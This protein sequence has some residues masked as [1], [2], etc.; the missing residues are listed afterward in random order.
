MLQGTC[1]NQGDNKAPRTKSYQDPLQALALK[2]RIYAKATSTVYCREYPLW[3]R[4]SKAILEILRSMTVHML[5]NPKQVRNLYLV[6]WLINKIAPK[7]KLQNKQHSTT[8]KLHQLLWL[9]LLCYSH[10]NIE[11]WLSF[12]NKISRHHGCHVVAVCFLL[13]PIMMGIVVRCTGLHTH[14]MVNECSSEW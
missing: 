10:D 9:I 11:G 13:T 12:G 5:G 6:K 4:S 2:A 8:M 1:L 7:Q 14:W 3:M